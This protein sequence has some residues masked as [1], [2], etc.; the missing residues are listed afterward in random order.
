MKD[1]KFPIKARFGWE[2]EP[3]GPGAE[4]V[5]FLKLTLMVRFPNRT[6]YDA[7]TLKTSKQ[8]DVMVAKLTLLLVLGLGASVAAAADDLDVL[9]GLE[10]EVRQLLL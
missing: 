9:I 6:G 8:A 10:E 3:T 2:T 7:E 4:A 1:P 5:I